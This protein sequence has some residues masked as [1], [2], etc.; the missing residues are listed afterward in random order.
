MSREPQTA[1]QPDSLPALGALVVTTD[2]K[3][4]GTVKEHNGVC[5]KVDA[6]MA[7]DYW[8]NIEVVRSM[9]ERQVMVEFTKDALDDFKLD[10]PSGAISA[11]PV[12]D[13]AEQAYTSESQRNA[14][15]GAMKAGY[16]SEVDDEPLRDQAE[17][18]AVSHSSA[19]DE[20]ESVIDDGGILQTPDEQ[21]EQ[22]R[23]MEEELAQ[24][25]DRRDA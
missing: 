15:R 20:A 9:S 14:T 22:R 24:Q 10:N 7:R 4:L 21:L 2:N 12:L 3:E 16:P 18:P 8:L 1:S 11:S 25:R 13:E 19:E 5:F 23:R 6:P 17:T